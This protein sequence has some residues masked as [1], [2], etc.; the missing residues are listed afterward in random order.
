MG[1]SRG[2]LAD[3]LAPQAKIMYFGACSLNPSFAAPGEVPPFVQMWDVH[4]LTI[5]GAVESRV[6]AMI[7]PVFP[8]NRQKPD[9]VLLYLAGK[10]WEFILQKLVS[11]SNVAD[12]VSYAN[13]QIQ[14]DPGYATQNQ[15]LY[16]KVLGNHGVKLSSSTALN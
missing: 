4:D 9:E 14:L 16:W 11:G 3:K 12:A 7:V 15:G 10:E 13:S 5:D 8:P 1:P 6:R 2:L